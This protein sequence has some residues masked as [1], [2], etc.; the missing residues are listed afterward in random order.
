[1]VGVFSL[2]R[3]GPRRCL[4]AVALGVWLAAGFAPT[5]KADA[6]SDFYKG[7]TITII[8]GGDAGGSYD[9]YARMLSRHLPRHMSGNP[10][11]TMQYMPG[12]GSV[13]A[14]NH[15]YN[16]AAQDG[17]FMLAPNR[18]AAFA[19]TLGQQGA[20]YEPAKLNW[21]GSLNNDVGVMQVWAN[22]PVKTIAD[23]RKTE[24]VIGA[25]SPLTDSQEY[26]TLLN[27]TLGTRFKMVL[28]Y[29]SMPALQ[30]SMEAGEI[31]RAHV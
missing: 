21:I 12:A 30:N 2:L 20:R 14:V 19:P 6:I 11:I 1:M 31:G 25:T 5:T 17:T 15:L 22:V 29:K 7:K 10:P 4:G 9:I 23:A 26:P 13:I 28:G 3:D 27:N 8:V 16:V 18:T 24:V